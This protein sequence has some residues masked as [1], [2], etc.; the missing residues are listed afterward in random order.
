[1]RAPSTSAPTPI[2]T[3]IRQYPLT[4]AAGKRL[5]AKALVAHPMVAEALR[6]GRLV[7]VAGTTNG[8]VAE[9]ILAHIGQAVGFVRRHFFR[10]IILPPAAALAGRGRSPLQD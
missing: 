2:E 7:I 3:V 9:E 8:Y 4:P 6:S 10:G 5:I 1:M